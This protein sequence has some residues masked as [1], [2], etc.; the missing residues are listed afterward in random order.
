MFFI[1]TFRDKL[2]NKEK[3]TGLYCGLFHW[4]CG[5]PRFTEPQCEKSDA[6]NTLPP[7]SSAL[8][9]W[10]APRTEWLKS[11]KKNPKNKPQIRGINFNLK[12]WDT[13]FFPNKPWWFAN[14]SPVG[15]LE[16]K[17]QEWLAEPLNHSHFQM[18]LQLHMNRSP[19]PRDQHASGIPQ[20]PWA[21]GKSMSSSYYM[22]KD[23]PI[24]SEKW[25]SWGGWR[26][27]WGGWRC[28]W[29]VKRQETWASQVMN[30]AAIRHTTQMASD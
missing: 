25:K 1:L 28:N 30:A 21:K 19:V 15:H 20:S 13:G 18:I 16:L 29:A 22:T 14:F 17:G 12:S 11:K 6:N 8:S 26:C 24:I 5:L 9:I 4:E 7:F 27:S 10:K 3:V 2:L 23:K